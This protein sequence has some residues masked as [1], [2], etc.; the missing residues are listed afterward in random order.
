VTNSSAHPVT[1]TFPST[2][3]GDV[4]LERDGV[5]HYR[6]SQGLVFAQMIEE[7]QLAP[8]EAWTCVLEGTLD[9]EPGPYEATGTVACRPAPPAAH[10]SVVVFGADPA[11]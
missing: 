6:W 9:V 11:G 5:E 10:A 8:G 1:L 4:S 3:G 7:R 2:Q